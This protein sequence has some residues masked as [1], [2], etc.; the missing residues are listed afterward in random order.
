VPP[1]DPSN[2]LA[3][4]R[5]LY[6]FNGAFDAGDPDAFNALFEEHGVLDRGSGG[7][8]TQ[9]DRRALVEG[10]RDRP[11]HRHFTTN[12]VVDGVASDPGRATAVSNWLYFEAVDGRMQVHGTGTYHDV[13]VKQDGRWL[14][15]KRVARRDA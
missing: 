5:L 3:I 1:I 7:G 6:E 11:S 4:Q 10:A 12:T 15:E 14:I 13:L 2:H 9:S 8:T